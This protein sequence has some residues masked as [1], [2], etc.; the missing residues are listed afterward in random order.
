MKRIGIVTGTRAEYG[1][2]KPVIQ[3]V[4]ENTNFTLVLIVTG[5]HLSP[6]FGMTYG[7]IES[8]GFDIDYKNE[9]LLSSDTAVGI[10]K[11]MGLGMI[12]FADIF[13]NAELD[14]LVVL[15]D[16]FEMFAAAAAAM[17]QR[18][19]IAHIHGGETTEGAIDEAFRHSITKMSALHFTCAQEYRA[20]VIQLGE[21]P[22][23]VHNVGSLGIENIRKLALLS[24]SKMEDF[25][26]IQFDRKVVM[27]TFHPVTLENQTAEGQFI[28]L[29][30]ALSRQEFRIVFTK[31]NADTDGRKL[32]SLID[33]YVREHQDS[34]V[35]FTSM[36]Q[37]KYLSAMKYCSLVIGNSSSGIIEAPA[38][39]V[40]T[41]NIG[42]RQKGR[43]RASSVVDCGTSVEEIGEA[44][45]K[46]LSDEFRNSLSC[47]KLPFEKENTSQ[48]IIEHI[49]SFLEKFNSVKKTFHDL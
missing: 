36:G 18:I 11:S 20:R 4:N 46:A 1:L 5:M 30:D 26:G 8:D 21:D 13:S 12:G 33:S 31:A 28:N 35:A 34:A 27:V 6:E 37:L 45:K 47:M 15:G 23:M 9:M 14:M 38:M 22:R 24:R 32:N 16:R 48:L 19:P 44:I 29:L 10:V 25:L 7:E 49:E 43:I 42:D 41:V 40:P 3:K 39:G 2:L 17:V